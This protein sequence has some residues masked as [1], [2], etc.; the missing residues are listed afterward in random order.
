[1]HPLIQPFAWL[2]NIDITYRYW[3][4]LSRVLRRPPGPVEPEASRRRY[5][6][7][8]SLPSH[9]RRGRFPEFVV[10]KRQ[11]LPCAQRITGVDLGEIIKV[12]SLIMV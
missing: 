3:H 4:E 6:S 7:A 12:T 8:C 9:F 10:D 5:Q 1:M 2:A 11:E